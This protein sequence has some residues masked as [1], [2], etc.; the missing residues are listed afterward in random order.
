MKKIN[1][2]NGLKSTTELDTKAISSSNLQRLDVDFQKTSATSLGRL[3][4]IEMHML[5]LMI[6]LGSGKELKRN[7]AGQIKSIMAA[8]TCAKII[9]SS[10]R[11]KVSV[12][13]LTRG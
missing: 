3:D 8:A 6:S 2:R 13:K 9:N 1:T 4:S 10:V 7:K 11:T 5:D 12:Y